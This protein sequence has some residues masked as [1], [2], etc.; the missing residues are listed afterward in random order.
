MTIRAC[1][2]AFLILSAIVA[3]EGP[4]TKTATTAG[5]RAAQRS[6]GAQGTREFLGLGAPPDAEAAKRGEKLYTANCSFCHG[7]KATGG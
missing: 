5:Q 7:A 1:L 3:Q 4:P 2:L 6:R